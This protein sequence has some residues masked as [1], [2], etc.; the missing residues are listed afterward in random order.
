M[1]NGSWVSFCV[2]QQVTACD[3]LF[4]LCDRQTDRRTVGL[5]TVS[6]ARGAHCTGNVS[7]EIVAFSSRDAMH[8]RY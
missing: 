7:S 8:P 3:P 6:Q 4:T 5:S 1:H 2:D